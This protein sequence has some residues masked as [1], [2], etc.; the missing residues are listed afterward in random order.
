MAVATADGVDAARRRHDRPDRV[1]D[2]VPRRDAARPRRRAVRRGSAHPPGRP[3]D[4]QDPG[5]PRHPRRA[6]SVRR[7]VTVLRYAA[8]TDTPDG[9]NPAGVVL[10]ATG[11]SDAEMLAVAA[12]VGFSETAFAIPRQDGDYDVRYFSPEV[13]VA[14]CGHATIATAVAL[15][16][17]LGPGRRVFHTPAGEIP[18]DTDEALTATLTSIVPEVHDVPDDLLDNVLRALGWSPEELDPALPPRHRLRRRELP[19]PRRRHP[20][21][22]RRPRLRLRSAQAD[23]ARAPDRH[24]RPRPPHG[25]AH[26]QRAQ[27]VPGRRRRGGPGHRRRGGRVRRLPARARSTSPRPRPSPSTR[28]STWAGRAC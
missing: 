24:R 12:D 7:R 27:P 14:F 25:R 4:R 21:A 22:A 9:G 23:D 6:S 15:A 10:D 2:R 13:E 18:V 1:R 8:F 26:V 5:T 17:R 20:R 19:D 3:R 28:A 16:E 11:M